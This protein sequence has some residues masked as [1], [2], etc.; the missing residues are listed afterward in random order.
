[1]YPQTDLAIASQIIAQR[2]R[3]AEL[4]RDMR[5][6]RSKRPLFRPS[7]RSALGRRAVAGAAR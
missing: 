5:V 4:Q 2:V 3:H 7:L 6:A 1:M